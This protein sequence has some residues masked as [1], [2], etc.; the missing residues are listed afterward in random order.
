[1][2]RDGGPKQVMGNAFVRRSADKFPV[3]VDAM[4]ANLDR[5]IASINT[6]TAT[7]KASKT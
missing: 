5:V 4:R 7:A 3:A 6:P 1:M 2:P